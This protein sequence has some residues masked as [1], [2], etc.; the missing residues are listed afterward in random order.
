MAKHAPALTTQALRRSFWMFWIL[1]AAFALRTY[2][3]TLKPVHFDEGINGHFVQTI[4]RDG[5]Y[6]Y[7]PTNFHGPLYFYI[8]MLAERLFGFG[9]FGFRFVTGLIQLAAIWVIGL[10]RRFVGRTAIYAALIA[11]LSPAFVFYSRYS[12]HE[13]LFILSQIAFSYGYFLYREEKSTASLWWMALAIVGL[14]TTKETFFVFL[15]TWAIAVYGL[16]FFE[17]LFSRYRT[18]EFGGETPS[19]QIWVAVILV[20]AVLILALFTGFFLYMPGAIDM[21]T[22]LKIWTGTGTAHS[23]HEKPF[24][25]WLDLMHTY[26]WPCLVGLVATPFIFFTRSISRE[27]RILTLV[28]FGSWLAYSLIPYKTPWLI[29]NVL[30]PLAFVAGAV[31]ARVTPPVK[32]LRGLRSGVAFLTFAAIFICAATMWRLNFHDFARVGEPY[33]YVQS[34]VDFKND[35]DLVYKHLQRRPEDLN[36]KVYAMSRD[37]WPEPYVLMPLPNVKWGQ[38]ENEDMH[39]A[40]VAFADGQDDHSLQSKRL[41]GKYFVLPFQVRDAYQLGH[42]YYAYDRFAD[43]MPAGTET[44]TGGAP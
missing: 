28:G 1:L 33:V 29:L 18:Y 41:H 38:A 3:L 5:Y 21:I 15:A 32:P 22:A 37:P 27:L 43:D 39:D 34:T 16:K 6:H 36:M 31:M 20:S 8:L 19:T 12:I 4:W 26:E 35:V 40:D 9:I 23:G 7:D 30:W 25:Y 24:E 17:R 2:Q 14:V 44:I 13:S 10:H 11:C 42:A